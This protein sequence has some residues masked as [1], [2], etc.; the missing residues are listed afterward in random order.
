MRRQAS[1]AQAMMDH[2]GSRSWVMSHSNV[3]YAEVIYVY[4][5]R[6]PDFPVFLFLV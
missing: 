1:R 2:D 5:L 3:S 4:G 6:I